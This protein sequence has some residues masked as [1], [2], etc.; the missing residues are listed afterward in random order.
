MGVAHG[1][2]PH[3]DAGALKQPGRTSVQQHGILYT[4][5]SGSFFG[6]EANVV[7]YVHWQVNFTS[8]QG[9]KCMVLYGGFKGNFIYFTISLYIITRFECSLIQL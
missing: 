7:H 4:L 3:G 5:S 6:G 9:L 2:N 8:Q 1:A